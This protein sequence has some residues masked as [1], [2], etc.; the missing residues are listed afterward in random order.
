MVDFGLS[1]TFKQNETLKTACGS[2]CY[3][4]PEM[5]A[6]EAYHGSRVDIWSCGVVLF[7]MVCGYLPFEDPDTN[8]LYKK[9]LDGKFEIPNWVS[10]E[11]SDLM[12]KILNIDPEERY[13]AKDICAHPWYLQNNTPVIKNLGLIIGKNKIPVESAIVGMLQQYGFKKE[14]AEVA[15]NANKHNQVTT[16][17][18]L[19]HKRYEKQGK[20]PSHFNIVNKS[21]NGGSAFKPFELED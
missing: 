10:D 2:P 19:L 5:I 14:E 15:L 8:L 20:L 18:Y 7:A 21:N 17:Y 4:A 11:C 16:V 6:G 3:A 9:I 1:N 12:K 13:T